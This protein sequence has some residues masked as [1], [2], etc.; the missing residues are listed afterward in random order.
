MMSMSLVSVFSCLNVRSDV[1]LFQVR[2]YVQ[3]ISG[4]AQ[5]RTCVGFALVAQVCVLNAR[6][7]CAGHIL[8]VPDVHA[9]PRRGILRGS[10]NMLERLKTAV[11]GVDYV[12]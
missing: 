9:Q 4:C 7:A 5:C 12:G 2:A 10:S 11:W 8:A 3:T 6:H 1:C